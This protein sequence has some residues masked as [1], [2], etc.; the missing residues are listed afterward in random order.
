MRLKYIQY[1]KIQIVVLFLFKINLSQGQIVGKDAYIK[2]TGIELGISGDGGFEGA[3][4]TLYPPLLGMHFRSNTNYFG[5]VANPQNNAWATYDGDFFTPGYPENG[6]GI[7]IG[8][9]SLSAS[10]NCYDGINKDNPPMIEILGNITKY[11]HNYSCYSVDWE[12]DLTSG[13]NL[14]FKINYLLEETSLFYTTTVS[15]TNNT[16]LTISDLYYYR[17]LDPDNNVMLNLPSPFAYY[18]QNTIES[19]PG[20]NGCNIA[21][22]SATQS[23]PWNSYVGFAADGN[24]WRTTYGGFANRSGYDLWTSYGSGNTQSSGSTDYEDKAISLSYYIQNIAPGSTETFKF[25]VILGSSS[26]SKAIDNLMYL[27]YPGSSTAPPAACTPYTDTV[28]TCG[29]TVPVNINGSAIND[30]SWQWSPAKG[31]STTTGTNVIANPTVTTLYEITGTPIV[32]CINTP[33]TF[34]LVVKVTN[35]PISISASQN[36]VCSGS[37]TI[38]KANGGTTY[39]W[40]DNLGTLNPITVTPTSTFIYTVSSTSSK[41][42]SADTNITINVNPLPTLSAIGDTI[43]IG[44]TATITANGGNTYSWSNNL[45]NGSSKT[46]NPMTTTTYTVTGTDENNCTNTTLAVVIANPLPTIKAG[47]DTICLGSIATITASNAN[48]YIWSNNLGS[49]SSVTVNP[50]ISTTYTVTGIDINGFSNTALAIVIVNPLPTVIVNGGTICKNDSIKITASGAKTYSWSNGLGSDSLLYVKPT[51]NTTYIVIGTDIN[52]CTNTSHAIV[53]VNPLPY[54]TTGG[55]TICFGSSV[56]ITSGN[57]NTYT[58]SNNLGNGSS[59]TVNPNT[60]TTYT[61][62]GTDINNC[63]N[64]AN[65]FVN[66]NLLPVVN[67]QSSNATTCYGNFVTLSANASIGS[68]PYTYAWS[69]GSIPSGISTLLVIST[70]NTTYIVSITDKNSCTA[71]SSVAVNIYNL[72]TVIAKGGTICKNDSIKITASGAKTYSWNDGL[73]SDSLLYVKPTITTTFSVTGTDTNSCSNTAN[74]VVYVN[75]LPPVAEVKEGIVCSLG[76]DITLKIINYNIDNSYEWFNV[77]SGGIIICTDSIYVRK[78]VMN[79]D[80]VYIETKTKDHNCKSSTRGIGIIRIGT[81]PTADFSYEPSDIKEFMPIN[82]INLSYSNL[83][84]G[85]MLYCWWL[86]IDGITSKEKNPTF[87]YNDSGKYLIKLQVENDDNCINIKTDTITVKKQ[88]DIWVPEAF[89]PNNDNKNDFLFV[90]GPVKTMHFE[91]YNMWG[92]KIFESIDQSNG[93]DGKFK[94]QDQ[95]EGNYI[96]ILEAETYDGPIIHKQNIVVLIR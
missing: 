94:G 77:S 33:V 46:V 9:N 73:G 53:N 35:N 32:S 78:H 84:S 38:L 90:K 64:T 63:S 17:N 86:D 28:N 45:G 50:A 30:Y 91:V 1:L 67:S 88:L 81:I 76:N 55:G 74:T 26:A 59:K 61:V 23:S 34:P 2:G 5:F 3:N 68:A 57:A 83:S 60:S 56:T 20:V 37:Q 72:P 48:T 41:C 89:S 82:F 96:W 36:P 69:A 93:W 25:V 10:N 7:T 70:A 13:T 21:H 49:G 51:I 65:I 11:S 24:N 18:T 66:V 79:A 52:R 29:G 19:Q 12:G 75:P 87:I 58:W 8:A 92:N 43:N 27:T 4:T 31:L 62:T 54:L 22:V 95:P 6:W 42:A 40:S 85:N 44:S 80:T 14:H 16:T 47:G 39:L 15:I 71:T